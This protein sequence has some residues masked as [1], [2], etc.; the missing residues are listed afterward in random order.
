MVSKIV[1]EVE[2]SGELTS[3]QVAEALRQATKTYESLKIK[4]ANGGGMVS[5]YATHCGEVV[6]VRR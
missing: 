6:E 3:D 2:H 1:I 5:K 4:I